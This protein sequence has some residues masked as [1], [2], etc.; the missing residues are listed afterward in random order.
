MDV[1]ELSTVLLLLASVFSI[2]NLRVLKLPQTIGLMVLAIILSIFVLITGL[3]FPSFLEA[4]TSLTQRFDFS[5]LLINVMLPF[6]LFAGAIT[7]N[8]SELLKDKV[9]ILFLASF[10]VV[11]STFAVGYGTYW[12]TQQSFLGLS[13]CFAM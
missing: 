10:G 9:T 2:I 8:L 11:F 12:L 6:L 5:T 7:I 13:G 3:I 4:M 1:L